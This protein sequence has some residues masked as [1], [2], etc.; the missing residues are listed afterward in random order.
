MNKKQKGK[1]QGVKMKE[2]E[3]K[4]KEV[5]NLTKTIESLRKKEQQKIKDGY[6]WVYINSKTKILTKVA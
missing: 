5:E 1:P 2:I 3:T 4:H 6:R